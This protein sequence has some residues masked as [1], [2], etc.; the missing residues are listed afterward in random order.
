MNMTEQ[1][2][3]P[4]IMGLAKTLFASVELCQCLKIDGFKQVGM[5]VKRSNE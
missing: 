1:S 4:L 5:D 2:E 3:I